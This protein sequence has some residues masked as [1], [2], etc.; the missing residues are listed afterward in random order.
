MEM[1]KVPKIIVVFEFFYEKNR[2]I[3]L[4]VLKT[5]SKKG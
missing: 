1:P 3:F 5:F 2:N 4:F